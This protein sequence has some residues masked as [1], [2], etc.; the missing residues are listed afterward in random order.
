MPMHLKFF[1]ILIL[2]LTI[3]FVLIGFRAVLADTP[4]AWGELVPGPHA[5]GFKT[6]EKYDY[7]RA[8]R[9][10]RDYFG[11]TIPGERARP[12]QVGIWYP[13]A[14]SEDAV[15]MVYGEYTYAY[16]EDASFIDILSQFHNRE[17]QRDHTF[18]SSTGGMADMQNL[19]LAAIK[20]AAPAEG[21][22]PLIL[23]H[24]HAEGSYCENAVLCE[25]LASQ[26]FIVAT[27]HPLGT[28][29][30]S[31]QPEANDL[32][33][34]L[35]DM[36]FVKGVMHDFTSTDPDRL[37]VVGWG[38]GSVTALW[39]QMQDT[40]VDAVVDLAGA[41]SFAEV[42]DLIRGHPYFLPAKMQ[43]PLLQLRP[44]DNPAPDP[45]LIDSLAYATRY[46]M[47]LPG[48]TSNDF[49]Q[50]PV[51]T[52]LL[53]DTTGEVLEASRAHYATISRYV[54]DFFTATLKSDET[55]MATLASAAGEPGGDTTHPVMH[56]TEAKDVPPTPEQFASIILTQG[57]DP[58]IEIYER[59]RSENPDLVLFQEA[60]L[61]GIGY[62]LL[63][64]GQTAEALK[65]FR[66]NCDTYANSAN[67]WDSYAEACTN[68]GETEEAVRAFQKSLEVLESDPNIDSGLRDALRRR[69]NEYL[70]Q[71]QQ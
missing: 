2:S 43:V 15:P 58:A 41:L 51:M 49:T 11:N 31:P 24:P 4:P 6:I 65:V 47:Y 29:R 68:A 66:M 45:S 35:R 36:A 30:L 5:V 44:A 32:T 21:P 56:I 1:R 8:F 7:T 61:N 63:Q 12:I 48:L 57:V 25:Y 16:P 42:F 23:Y 62:R 54:S 55:A 46:R 19:Q 52:A 20:N 17:L 34:I 64:S 13:A 38:L 53:T 40:D 3:T 33:T 60:Q 37:G 27:T 26:G 70:E 71:L 10:K 28:T 39:M 50:Y 18:T 9:A 67:T 22:F 69:A 14:I 59:F